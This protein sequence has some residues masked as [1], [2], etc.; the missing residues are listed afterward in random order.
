[1]EDSEVSDLSRTSRKLKMRYDYLVLVREL[2]RS[3]SVNIQ[4]LMGT[5][6]LIQRGP[7]R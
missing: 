1:M 4:Y 6:V 7:V 5:S 2:V 3:G